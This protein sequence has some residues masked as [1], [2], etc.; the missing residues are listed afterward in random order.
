M[1]YFP[2]NFL[3]KHIIYITIFPFLAHCGAAKTY[4]AML[5]SEVRSTGV[6]YTVHF[7]RLPVNK[8]SMLEVELQLELKFTLI[9][10]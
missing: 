3:M 1:L 4:D 5:N 6:V 2:Q 10:G 9:L 8:V 7:G